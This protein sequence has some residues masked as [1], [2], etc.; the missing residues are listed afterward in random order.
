M[1]EPADEVMELLGISLVDAQGGRPRGGL[2]GRSR[3]T[4]S[5][6]GLAQHLTT[7]RSEPHSESAPVSSCRKKWR[8]PEAGF[9]DS[10]GT[11]MVFGESAGWF[12]IVQYNTLAIW[13]VEQSLLAGHL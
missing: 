6:L 1:R 4:E 9:T 10:G 13:D 3:G 11:L 7:L 5:G 12:V 2:L 8:C